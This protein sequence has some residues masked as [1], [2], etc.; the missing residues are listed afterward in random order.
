MRKAAWVLPSHIENSGGFRT[1][2]QNINCL[3]L[4]GYRCDVY[5]EKRGCTDAASN[6][7]RM[8]E[9]YFGVCGCRYFTTYKFHGTY[10]IMFATSWKTAEA[11]KQYPKATKKVYFI[12]DFEAAFYPAGTEYLAACASYCQ[13]LYPITIGR[14]LA[15]KMADHYHVDA[16]YFDFCAD[17]DIYRDLHR[18]REK[19]VCFIYQPHK[20]R[21]CS[22]LGLQALGI[23]SVLR[24]DVKIYLFGSDRKPR[25][26]FAYESR[27]CLSVEQCN[28]LYNQCMA[29]LCI[30][31]TNPSRIPFEMMAAGL[32][33]VD[34][35]LENNLYDMPQ[36]GVL[37]AHY[38]P[39]SIAAALLEL[40]DHPKKAK[41]MSQGGQR[42]M[43]DRTLAYGFDQFYE[44]VTD[45][46]SDGKRKNRHGMKA[47]ACA[48]PVRMYRHAPVISSM[49][50]NK[51]MQ[52]LCR[53]KNFWV[54]QLT[55][56]PPWWIRLLKNSRIVRSIYGRL[57]GDSL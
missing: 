49:R 34:L 20:P 7:K 48:E 54:A 36:E 37:L 42:F 38:T 51:A 45:V 1:V 57:Q 46:L 15:A 2:F 39:Q 31:A 12:Q 33:V 11:V 3:L 13:G 17:T 10:D 43:K 6:L 19:A 41:Q 24:P 14:W 22:R 47:V 8:A 29:G 4:H 23:V 16:R 35:H 44:A 25:V 55:G 28:A 5:I 40:L 21:R 18:K 27:G 30:S 52:K 26:P 56:K 50:E 9:Q 32:P 53:C